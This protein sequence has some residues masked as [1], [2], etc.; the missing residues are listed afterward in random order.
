MWSITCMYTVTEPLK[1]GRDREKEK[2]K[3]TSETQS[4]QD[5]YSTTSN[6][7]LYYGDLLYFFR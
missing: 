4:L 6:T 2:K 7:Y 5:T 1:P 3:P